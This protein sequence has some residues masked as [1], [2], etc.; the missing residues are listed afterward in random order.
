[1]VAGWGVVA[2]VGLS[3]PPS[4]GSITS[5]LPISGGFTHLGQ[6][7]KL[8]QKVHKR[9]ALRTIHSLSPLWVRVDSNLTTSHEGHMGPK[10]LGLHTHF[11]FFLHY[12]FMGMPH[13]SCHLGGRWEG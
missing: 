6:P 10:L 9:A 12:L 2:G 3:P 5:F 8:A 4:P 1:M 11:F 7:R 13:K